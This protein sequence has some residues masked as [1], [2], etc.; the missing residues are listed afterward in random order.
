MD[1]S[2]SSRRDVFPMSSKRSSVAFTESSVDIGNYS[3]GVEDGRVTS[4]EVEAGSFRSGSDAATTLS[5]EPFSTG[6]YNFNPFHLKTMIDVLETDRSLKKQLTVDNQLVREICR[7]HV[8][9]K[10]DELGADGIVSRVVTPSPVPS[11]QRQRT[12]TI[13]ESTHLQEDDDD[14]RF[15]DV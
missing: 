4:M 1:L 8:T 3:E 7:V 6:K 10:K 5:N 9:A 12:P 2:P 13:T 11:L 15:F 14:E